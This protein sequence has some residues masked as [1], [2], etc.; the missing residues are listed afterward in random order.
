[1]SEGRLHLR[2]ISERGSFIT[3]E[4]GEGAGKSTQIGHLLVNL[5]EAG[6][7]AVSYTHLDVYKR[8]IRH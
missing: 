7:E 2:A 8:Q 5:R 6:I 1:M 3:L 4:G